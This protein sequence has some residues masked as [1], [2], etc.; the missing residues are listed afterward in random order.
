MKASATPT[1]GKDDP[2]LKIFK[3]REKNLGEFTQRFRMEYVTNGS[4]EELLREYKD[5][6]K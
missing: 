6:K 2:S 1:D 4:I 5:H 3:V